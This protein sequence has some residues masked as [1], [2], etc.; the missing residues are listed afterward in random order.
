MS[1]ELTT[2]T[3][4]QTMAATIMLISIW[5]TNLTPAVLDMVQRSGLAATLGPERMHFN[6]ESAVAAYQN[7]RTV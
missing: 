6:L 4:G 5:L 7:R 2:Q 1:A 3:T